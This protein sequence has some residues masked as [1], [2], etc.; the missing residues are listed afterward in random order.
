MYQVTSVTDQTL[1]QNPPPQSTPPAH[2]YPNDTLIAALARPAIVFPAEQVAQL[3]RYCK[4]LWDWNEKI[5]LTRHTTYEKF[6]TRD[7]ADT[8]QLAGLVH[9]KEEILDV[10]SG[11]GVPG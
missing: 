6:V 7:L 11:G 4:L 1:P 5:N 2:P 10:G 9:P 8:L 3:D